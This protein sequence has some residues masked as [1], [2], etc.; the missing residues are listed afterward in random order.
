M[1]ADYVSTRQ[2][3][4]P[5]HMLL[6]EYERRTL[7][8]IFGDGRRQHLLDVGS[9]TGRLLPTLLA[10]ADHVTEI[11]REASFVERA[12]EALS[13][14]LRD[15]VTFVCGTVG[16]LDPTVSADGAV[17]SGLLIYLAPAEISE[18]AA[19]I[20]R[21]LPAGGLLYVREP[22][23]PSYEW[24]RHES[25]FY[26]KA[27][28]RRRETLVSHLC[29]EGYFAEKTFGF[30][31]TKIV[32]PRILAKALDRASVPEA[33]VDRLVRWTSKVQAALARP[34]VRS[35]EGRRLARTL[36]DSHENY[37]FAWTLLERTD[38]AAVDKPKG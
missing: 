21:H 12:E 23:S 31:P 16:E 9:G 4:A 28:Y 25:R 26:P 1:S 22:A 29:S 36:E 27:Y 17:I 7:A 13:P 35:E 32:A 33:A 5:L 19:Q 3:P 37:A 8:S 34:G 20:A 18:I 6:T 38:R 15:R 30:F 24:T 11:E 10:H 2:R 14:S